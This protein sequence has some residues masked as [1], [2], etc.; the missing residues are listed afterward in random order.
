[1]DARTRHP[2]LI[3]QSQ[4][5]VPSC[6]QDAS[7]TRPDIENPLLAVGAT[8]SRPSWAWDWELAATRKGSTDLMGLPGLNS[9][10]SSPFEFIDIVWMSAANGKY[11]G[12]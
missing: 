3:G 6:C 10:I 5:R 9:R 12:L 2:G 4:Q 8:P 7:A 11:G 1:M